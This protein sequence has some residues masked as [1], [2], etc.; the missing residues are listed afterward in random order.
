[1]KISR[2]VKVKARLDV[3]TADMNIVRRTKIRSP[4]GN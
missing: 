4:V 3:P 2:G 1:M